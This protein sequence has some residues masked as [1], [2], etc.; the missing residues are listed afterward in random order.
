MHSVL[1]STKKYCFRHDQNKSLIGINK[2]AVYLVLIIGNS[3]SHS[4]SSGRGST[5]GG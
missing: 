4:S 5:V 3:S 2:H 1:L